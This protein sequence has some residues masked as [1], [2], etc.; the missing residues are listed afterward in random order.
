LTWQPP[1]D[2]HDLGDGRVRVT[3]VCFRRS[4]GGEAAV[5]EQN[6]WLDVYARFEATAEVGPVNVGVSLHD[7]LNRLVFARGWINDDIEPLHLRPGQQVLARFR[8]KL[9]L[10]PGEYSLGLAAAEP[11]RD[12]ASPNGWNQQVGGAR[13]AELPHAAKLAVVPRR[14]GR[15]VSYGIA[16]LPSEFAF[17][18][19]DPAAGASQ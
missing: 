16:T 18:V 5:V 9:D 14:D 8:L 10:E 17:T 7:R 15:R 2:A 4:D 11:L 13:F 3:G 1:D 19:R 12:P 6:Q